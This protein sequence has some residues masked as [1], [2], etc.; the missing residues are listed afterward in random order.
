MAT[1]NMFAVSGSVKHKRPAEMEHAVKAART[2]TAKQLRLQSC[3]DL[4]NHPLSLMHIILSV[5]FIPALLSRSVCS[6][7]HA[8]VCETPKS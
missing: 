1:L 2:E 5:S 3:L 8:S 7:D 6:C 4:P